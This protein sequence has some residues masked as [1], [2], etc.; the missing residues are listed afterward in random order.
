[1][2]RFGTDASGRVVRLPRAP[3]EKE[4]WDREMKKPIHR[5]RIWWALVALGTVAACSA[6]ETDSQT[7][8]EA[9]DASLT[10]Q[11]A[12][13]PALLNAEYRGIFAE[14]VRMTDGRYQGAPFVA[15]G[16]SRPELLL[17]RE[18]FA[19]GD[20]SQDGTDEV[21]ALLARSSGGSGTFF[22]LAVMKE[23]EGDLSNAETVLLGDR[24]RVESLEI[25]EGSLIVT[26]LEH[27][28]ED[29]A[30]CPSRRVLRSWMEHQ[31]RLREVVV[32]RGKLIY[33][34]ESHELT[35]C[36]E[37][38]PYWVLDGTNGDLPA[39]YQDLAVGAYDSLLVE[40]RGLVIPEPG[41]GFG[42]GYDR[43][44]RVTDLYRAAREGPGCAEDLEDILFR[45][46]GV[47]PFW[48]L[49]IRSD[50]LLL[51]RLG[52]ETRS[53]G[54][55]VTSESASELRWSGSDPDGGSLS[56]AIRPRR[57]VDPMSGSVFPLVAEATVDGDTLRGCAVRGD[58]GR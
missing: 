44:I 39:V 37:D 24:V 23:V 19:R 8:R 20:L 12:I 18:R 43:Q 1:M 45:T 48:H 50:S 29:P 52:F 32:L 21:V 2:P 7:I 58:A 10:L 54:I 36:G 28:P 26:L 56:V 25:F 38:D 14:P 15:G 17:I 9:P 46:R 33:G 11:E 57:C 30:C 42:E 31:E 55:E 53:F 40:V 3:L 6:G 41:V 22:Y 5:S 51:N 4:G 49:D 34:H 27:G 47:E 16:A 13:P 35:P